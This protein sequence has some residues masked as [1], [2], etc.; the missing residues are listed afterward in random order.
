MIVIVI[1]LPGTGKTTF[2]RAL[3]QRLNGLHLNTDIL[4]DK[5]NLRGQYDRHTKELIY[6]QLKKETEFA[7]LAKKDVVV[8]GTFYK[9]SLRAIYTQLAQKHGVPIHWI[10]V[11]APEE[12]IRARVEKKRVYSEADFQV[13]LK[14]KSRYEPMVED[15]LQVWNNTGRMDDCLQEALQY[16]ERLQNEQ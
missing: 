15:H 4:R 1:G 9:E 10:E 11:K 8:D 12:C 6:N 7:I 3:A 14:V 5:L 16:L 13:Y 2:S